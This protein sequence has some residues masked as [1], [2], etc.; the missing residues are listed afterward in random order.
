MRLSELLDDK[1]NEYPVMFLKFFKEREHAESLQKGGLRMNPVNYYVKREEEDGVKGLGDSFEA[2]QV[3]NNVKFE[4]RDPETGKL[5]VSDDA[6]RA[7]IRLD[8][9]Q[10]RP[11]FCMT[12][13][14]SE[15]VEV[16]RED[17]EFYHGRVLFTEEQ[18]ERFIKDFGKYVLLIS[19]DKFIER[20][21][22]KA[23]EYGWT[24]KGDKV[25]YDDFSVNNQKR[26]KAFINDDP[27]LYFWKDSSLSYQHEYRIIILNKE[28]TEATTYDIGDLSEFST[29]K[30]AGEILNKGLDVMIRKSIEVLK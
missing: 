1:Y 29:I 8:R 13:I 12:M 15:M 23:K 3:M 9:H 17:E 28:I 16:K 24:L 26:M 7:I 22:Q 11:L 20:I 25:I 2:S 19:P 21:K 5:L 6:D 27:S 10:Y 14:T 18:K 30:A 4:I